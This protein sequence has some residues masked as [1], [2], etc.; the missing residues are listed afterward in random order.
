MLHLKTK[1]AWPSKV[2]TLSLNMCCKML[3]AD[4]TIKCTEQQICNCC[5][6]K[7][8]RLLLADRAAAATE[9]GRAQAFVFYLTLMDRSSLDE[10]PSGQSRR[11]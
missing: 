7:V 3:L 1:Q 5:C 11:F 6:L 9:G 4:L 10:P 8:R 2:K